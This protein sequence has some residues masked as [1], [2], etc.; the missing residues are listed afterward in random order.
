M[1]ATVGSIQVLFQAKFDTYE[2]G[3]K[4]VGR[5]TER[6]GGRMTKAV[7]RSERA[8]QS[9]NRTMSKLRG[10]EF[11]VLSLA[12]LRTTNSVERLRAS[13]VAVSALAGGFGAAFT[14]KGLADYSDTFK[15][16]GNRLRIVKGE[17]QSLADVQE[18]IFQIAQRSRSEYAATGILFARISNASKRLKINQEDVLR[19]T[20]TIQKSFLVGGS[21]P[22]EAVQS[23]IQLSQGIA[24][25][26]LQGDELRSVLENPALGQLI[27]DQ[28]SE[29]NIGK[30]REMA[31]A[32]ELTAGVIVNAF[33][34]ASDEIDRLFESTD[35]TIGQAFVKLDNAILNYI[36]TSETAKN[37]SSALVVAI[38][39][40]TEN[41]DTVGD[42]IAT[43]T[44][45]AAAL[46]G[47]RGIG[48][49]ANRMLASGRAATLMNQSIRASAKESLNLAQAEQ[50][51]ARTDM[52][53][54]RLAL[55]AALNEGKMSQTQLARVQKKTAASIVA[56]RAAAQ[57]ATIAQ[58]QFNTA[59]RAT[60]VNAAVT[61]TAMRGLSAS[62][63]FLGGPLGVALLA[64]GGAWFVMSSRAN[65][66]AE[67]TEAASQAI[68]DA[69]TEIAVLESLAPQAAEG[70]ERIAAGFKELFATKGRAEAVA[71]INDVEAGVSA[72]VT[73]LGQLRSELSRGFG[74][75]AFDVALLGMVTNLQLGNVTAAEFNAEMDRIVKQDGSLADLASEM[76]KLAAQII[77]GKQS[78]ERLNDELDAMDGKEINV[79][80]N[81]GTGGGLFDGVEKQKLEALLKN[82]AEEFPKAIEDEIKKRFKNN[83][84]SVLM[85]RMYSDVLVGVDPKKATAAKLSDRE[86]ALRRLGRQEKKRIEKYIEGLERLKNTGAELFLD[87]LD[88]KVVSTA[89][90]FDIAEDQI[91]KFTDAAL[92]GQISEIPAQF[93]LIRGELEKIQKNEDLVGF[94]DGFAQSFGGLFSDLITRS[95]GAGEAFRDFGN[96]IQDT[97]LQLLVIEPLIR[98]I[99]SSLTGFGGIGVG[100]DP[101]G[102]PGD[103]FAGMR[104]ATAHSGWSVGKGKA[105]GSRLVGPSAFDGA[106][107]FH[108]GVRN[109]EIAAILEKNETVL[110][111]GQSKQAAAM[112]GSMGMNGGGG[113]V[114]VNVFNNSGADV[115]KQTSRSGGKTITDI[116]IGEVNRG[117]GDG[118]LNGSMASQ[119]NASPTKKQR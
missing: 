99:R 119:F 13:M 75:T 5:V 28:V 8:T 16:V 78:A 64:L 82:Q 44:V 32:G 88:Q 66:A 113:N 29:G 36:G 52:V 118:K 89:R 23:A 42:S 45:A 40:V 47:A 111:K 100:A 69:N 94:I 91:K 56:H 74:D 49:L 39:A 14:L 103:P 31:A 83:D 11:R 97:V 30:L 17:A 1:V 102:A 50:K 106:P 41:F 105:P 107:R 85:Q 81:L 7:M 67:A 37:S 104:V 34:E 117:I 35:Q 77:S 110:T 70:I 48:G 24:S 46:F 98:S 59:I 68:E 22:V 51:L 101:F 57:N 61:S 114:E 6:E 53:K 58:T 38:N 84:L 21:T 10:R 54:Q 79:K 9:L 90:S 87:D 43:L 76:K 12:A 65:A 96:K 80:I 2:R 63:A 3:V 116:I 4:R 27:A 108:S 95:K 19:V 92:S 15:E 55:N 71:A 25:D 109:N 115:Q 62:M 93:Q 60:S 73:K 72:A 26:R 20:E 112:L 33:R 18:K 86:K